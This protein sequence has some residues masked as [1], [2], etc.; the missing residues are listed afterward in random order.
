MNKTALLAAT[1]IV[2]LT[3][4]TASAAGL[5]PGLGVNGAKAHAF[6]RNAPFL[7][8]GCTSVSDVY[9][10]TGGATASAVVSDNFTSGHFPTYTNALA[11]D[12]SYNGACGG[13]LEV[14]LMGTYAG[15]PGPVNSFDITIYSNQ[16]GSAK[17]GPSHPKAV[18]Y[19][20]P[21]TACF[22]SSTPGGYANFYCVLPYTV[23]KKGVYKPAAKLKAGGVY[24]VSA[25]ANLSFIHSSS[26]S[27]ANGEWYWHTADAPSFRLDDAVWHEGGGFGTACVQPAWY[28]IESCVTATPSDLA[29][30]IWG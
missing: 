18:M 19:A 25:V 6:G 17:K 14:D 9:D 29:F 4:G 7:R 28:E 3:A 11:D 20:F 16:K 30:R 2:A 27:L 24:W 22:P 10:T 21:G 8:P 26:G 13:A 1:A 5:H 12:F 23:S 15:W